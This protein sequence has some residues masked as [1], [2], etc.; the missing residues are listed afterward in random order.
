MPTDLQNKSKYRYFF[1]GW[2]LC[3]A[4]VHFYVVQSY[5]IH[6]RTALA[7][8]L[9]SN[10]LLAGACLLIINNMRYYL[11]RKERYGYLLA[12]SLVLSLLW[13]ALARFILWALHPGYPD[14]RIILAE[15][16]TLRF[17]LAF[18]M[19][20]CVSA[21]SLLWF[22]LREQKQA[23]EQKADLEKMAKEAELFKLRQQLHP[24]FLFN[25]LNSINA[26][27]GSS[28]T[29]AR[30][31]VHQLS[32]FLRGTLKKEEDQWVTLK[33]ELE[34]LGLY[35]EIEKVRFG[36]RLQTSIACTPETQDIRIPALLLQPVLENAIKFGLYD[37]TGEALITLQ[38]QP[39]GNQLE[40]TVSNP[41]DP[42]TSRALKGT[43]FGLNAVQRR[44]F[45]LFGRKDL[46]KT[47]AGDTFFKT[48]LTIPIYAESD[49]HR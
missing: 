9:I 49:T 15:S 5:G 12:L 3:W 30:R 13:I 8:S 18:L 7:D 23:D 41:Y 26:L 45:L 46:L 36:N 44:L 14:Y 42:A 20:G 40:I 48:I 11:P 22:T 38:A 29:E 33:E 24:H 1:T 21:M 37:T 16:T 47:V 27:I 4:A 6:L 35:L 28:P 39:V 19:T 10:A 32:D 17:G 31:M 25:S 2:W 43:G 34:Y